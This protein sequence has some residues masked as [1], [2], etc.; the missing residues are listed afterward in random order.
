MTTTKHKPDCPHF[1]APSPNHFKCH[2]KDTAPTGIPDHI[3]QHIELS[4]EADAVAAIRAKCAE[5]ENH[6]K[7]VDY[8][9][10]RLKVYKQRADRLAEYACHNMECAKAD[11]TFDPAGGYLLSTNDS[12]CTC[13]LAE[14]LNRD[15]ESS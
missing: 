2:C 9:V 4:C 8:A 11:Y 3:W 10:E 12:D 7:A 5:V 14:L 6:I 15:E 13:G 1:Y